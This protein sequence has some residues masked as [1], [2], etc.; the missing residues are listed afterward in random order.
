MSTRI[1]SLIGVLLPG[2]L[3]FGI[4]TAQKRSNVQ[5]RRHKVA[6]T[7]DLIT[8]WSTGEESEESRSQRNLRFGAVGRLY[9]NQAPSNIDVD[10]K[11]LDPHLQI[12]ENLNRSTVAVVGLGGVGSWAAEA[13]CRSGVG[14]LI[15]IDLDDI[16]ISNTNRQLHA[17][18]TSIGMMKIDEMRRRLIHINPQCSVTNIHEFV[19]ETNVHDILDSILPDVNVV[20][21]AIDSRKAKTA[22]IA[23]CVEKKIP[24]VT[25]GGAAGK[26]DPTKIFA[27][28]L[29]R[30]N[31]DD[32]LAAVRRN[33]RKS[34]GFS[35]GKKFRE[36]KGKLPKKWKIPAVYSTEETNEISDVEDKLGALRRCDGALGTACF[37]TGAFGFVAAGQVVDMIAMNKFLRPSKS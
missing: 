23:A 12:I 1:A 10:S 2:C 5:F 3:A 17:T 37:V 25:C 32:L 26:R 29:A 30:V 19:T 36:L 31:G 6:P 8:G 24:I 7:D 33:L 16:C 27:S 15:L 13:L 14:N 20:L 4:L 34:Y 18:S 35:E 21:D 11:V 9:A 28:D 22:L